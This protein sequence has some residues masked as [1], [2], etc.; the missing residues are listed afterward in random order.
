M[1]LST[2]PTCVVIRPGLTSPLFW[3]VS[4]HVEPSLPCGEDVLPK[5]PLVQFEAISFKPVTCF[6]EDVDP[7]LAI[8]SFQGV[9]ESSSVHPQAFFLW[10]K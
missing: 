3:T 4:Y 6:L 2:I 8:L 10:A 9:A 7:H 1:F 5:L